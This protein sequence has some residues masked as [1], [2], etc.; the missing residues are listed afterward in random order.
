M[1][2][3]QKVSGDPDDTEEIA[4]IPFDN[5]HGDA[6]V[7]LRSSDNVTFYLHKSTLRMSSAF[8][9]SMFSLPQPSASDPAV[10]AEE[11]EAPLPIIE[12]TESSQI[13]DYLLRV[14]YPANIPAI[15]R[16][17]D[18]VPLLQGADKY[19]MPLVTSAI[20]T[21]LAALCHE[22][23]LD[24]YA[25]A[26]IFHLEQL[27]ECAAEA[28]CAFP[29][30]PVGTDAAQPLHRFD[31]YTPAMNDI[32]SSS[33]FRLLQCYQRAVLDAPREYPMFGKT[34]FQSYVEKQR[35]EENFNF[36]SPISR[37]TK[38]CT[39]NRHFGHQSTSKEFESPRSS[40][41]RDSSITD[42]VIRSS[43]GTELYVNS[44]LIGI[45][46]SVLAS[47]LHESRSSDT[48][49]FCQGD[50]E[51]TCHI[52]LPEDGETLTNLLSLCYPM[53]DPEIKWS[54]D[55]GKLSKACRLLQAALKYEV[56]RAALFA[57]RVCVE[58][59]DYWPERVF[60]IATK[61]GWQ[62][63]AELAA[64]HAVY[65]RGEVY[66]PEM[67][68]VPAAAY[69]RLLV[70]RQQC[71]DITVAYYTYVSFSKDTEHH[72]LTSAPYWDLDGLLEF[73]L[74]S[75]QR[76]WI[77]F[78][79]LARKKGGLTNVHALQEIVPSSLLLKGH[80]A[81][82]GDATRPDV[83]VHHIH[84]RMIK[85]GQKLASVSGIVSAIGGY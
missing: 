84:R 46:S 55:D 26:C 18:A 29:S 20:Q 13:L 40:F 30:P 76:F 21:A 7:A 16:V 42:T 5:P 31:E 15:T 56:Q 47:L 37:A 62:D 82:H 34:P 50:V 4:P 53:P 27:A 6:D 2:S 35:V 77:T 49:G 39:S 43:D 68:T 75:E 59:I 19:Q 58:A 79:Q 78:H 28:F 83:T 36:C 51:I 70:Y 8:F 57:K 22:H 66:V 1:L 17:E 23:T 64:V 3:V 44:L 60:F 33:Y 25:L 61:Y 14:V 9:A 85:L 52:D 74:F 65:N 73:D 41:I 67:E 32:P 71:R 38:S 24:V 63:V 81:R 11:S 54:M 80:R 12:V 10:D 69:R 45:A 48:S 72:V